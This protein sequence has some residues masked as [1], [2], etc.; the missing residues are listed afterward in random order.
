MGDGGEVTVQR[1]K[2]SERKY[3]E[4]VGKPPGRK[5]EV[6]RWSIETEERAR[7]SK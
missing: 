6:K 7:R 3:K 1:E 4:K 5:E 2:L